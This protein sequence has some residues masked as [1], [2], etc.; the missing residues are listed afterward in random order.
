MQRSQEPKPHSLSQSSR[1]L[2]L[3]GDGTITQKQLE[4]EG[5]SERRV[6]ESE[7]RTRTN[8]VD[9]LLEPQE[10]S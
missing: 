1:G 7:R 4:S 5:V 8:S 3:K 2:P 9:G 6:E 10:F